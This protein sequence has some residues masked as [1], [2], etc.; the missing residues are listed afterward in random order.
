MYLIIVLLFVWIDSAVANITTDFKLHTNE[1][2]FTSKELSCEIYESLNTKEV[3]MQL[4]YGHFFKYDKYIFC[5]R[6]ENGVCDCHFY[7]NV[8]R[9]GSLSCYQTDPNYGKGSILDFISSKP[10]TDIGTIINTDKGIDINIT[11]TGFRHF[12][13]TLL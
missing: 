3:P 12:D 2:T 11:F 4:W 5:Q 7:L 10:I 9:D 1:I 6:D 8:K 13:Q